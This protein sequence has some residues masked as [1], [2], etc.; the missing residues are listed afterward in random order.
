M[1]SIAAAK[2]SGKPYQNQFIFRFLFVKDTIFSKTCLFLSKFICIKANNL[3]LYGRRVKMDDLTEKRELLKG[4]IRQ[5]CAKPGIQQTDIKGF[6][7]ALKTAPTVNQ[8]CFYHPMAMVVLQGKKQTV[9]GSQSFTYQENHLVVTSI[10]IPTVGSIVEASLDKPFMTLIMDLDNDVIN[11]L[12]SESGYLKTEPV[13]RGMGVAD[14]D[15]ALLDAFIRLI[16]LLEQPEHQ[17]VM[18][19]IIIKEIHYLL[20]AS[21]L[22]DILRSA[23]IKGSQNNQ[24]AK[25][26]EWLKINY[27]ESLKIDELAQKFNM[28]QSSFYR[29]FGKVTSLSPLQ[30]QK[31]LRL[32][33]AQRLMLT[34]NF[35]AENACY[36]V[37]YESAS[38]FNREYKRMFGLPPKANV[39]Q[40]RK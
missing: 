32:H 17:K 38:Q 1:N 12:L 29:H 39:R 28:A 25:A 7:M 21:P 14:V 19:P 24:I 4:K 15:A 40:M 36:A 31:Q 16:N 27:T 37:G 2:A 10:D 22:G 30:Y 9:L 33:E 13:R 3:Y 23:N 20:L 26:I 5:F 8:H 18:V 35:S 11:Q 6:R 34:E